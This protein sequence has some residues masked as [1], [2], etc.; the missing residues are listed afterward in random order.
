M[1]HVVIWYVNEFPPPETTIVGADVKPL[2]P[3]VIVYPVIIVVPPFICAVIFI[4]PPPLK[5]ITGAAVYQLPLFVIVSAV[6]APPET[7][8]VAVAPVPIPF[9]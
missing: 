1:T 4:K 9:I 3:D 6:I 8:A 7:A 2:P 5:D